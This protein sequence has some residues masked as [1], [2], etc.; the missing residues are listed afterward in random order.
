MPLTCTSPFN[1]DDFSAK[2]LNFT[3]DL[4][5]T[6]N[7]VLQIRV[8]EMISLAGFGAAPQK[9]VCFLFCPHILGTEGAFFYGRGEE[10]GTAY[11]KYGGTERVRIGGVGGAFLR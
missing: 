1:E 2:F 8:R 3:P 9:K 6:M 11:I 5:R 10:K 7:M 4:G